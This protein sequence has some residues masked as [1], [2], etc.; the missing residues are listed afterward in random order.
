[1]IIPYGRAIPKR[2]TIPTLQPFYHRCGRLFLKVIMKKAAALWKKMQGP[3]SARYLPLADLRW[4]LN[5]QDS[6]PAAYYRDL[7]LSN[8]IA[9]VRYK[10]GNVTYQRETFISYPAKVLVMRIT[11]DKKRSDQWNAWV[12][13][14][15]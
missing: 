2:E 4:R 13:Q 15:N 10:V 14:A 12:D 9:T 3:Y 7:D 8:A 11:A 6:V 5:V 1:M